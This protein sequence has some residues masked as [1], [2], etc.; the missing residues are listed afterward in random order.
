MTRHEFGGNWTQLKLAILKDYLQFY[1]IALKDQPFTLHYVDAFAGTGKQ[2]QKLLDE[3]GD[4]LP[5]EDLKGSV[6]HAL[7][8]DPGFH[9][10]HFNDLN[11]EHCEVLEALKA[12]HPNKNI[13]ITQK[14]A[15]TFVQNFCR[16][17][18]S[19]D[20]AVIFLDPYG[21]QVDWA[22][23]V[24]VAATKKVD[25]WL[26][27]PLSTLMRMTP[28]DGAKVR[29]EWDSRISRL[30]GTKEWMD[31]LYKPK[32]QPSIPDLFGDL[33]SEDK[34]ERLNVEELERFV[35]AKL[36]DEFA[37]VM[38]PVTLRCNGSPLFS[39]YFAVS[40]PRAVNLAR[41]VASSI[42]NKWQQF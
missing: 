20:R 26:L 9:H 21:A 2:D 36:K 7:E 11:P 16:S 31:A 12:E 22:T 35:T 34:L 41:K 14:D 1:T 40:N 6:T 33:T 42:L 38:R 19:S 30:L 18:K 29:Q 24:Q 15:N 13:N 32:E 4:L 23:L 39:F 17:L 28:K 3:A 27:F 25:L 10:Y 5:E 37:D 8:T